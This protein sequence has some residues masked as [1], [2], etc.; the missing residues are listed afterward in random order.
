VTAMVSAAIVKKMVAP[1]IWLFEGIIAA[2]AGA[3]KV[4][5]LSSIRLQ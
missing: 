4:L 5:L 1:D 3:E 2:R